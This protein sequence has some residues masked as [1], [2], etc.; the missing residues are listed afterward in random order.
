MRFISGI[1]KTR[2]RAEL[3]KAAQ[4]SGQVI[5][6]TQDGTVSLSPIDDPMLSGINMHR[7]P[8][9]RVME[10]AERQAE[11]SRRH[12]RGSEEDVPERTLV[13]VR[14]PSLERGM[15][16]LFVAGCGGGSRV[17]EYGREERGE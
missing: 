3:E 13:A 15:E 5:V 9:D 11:K 1:T 8:T 14:S 7:T 4:A 10:K 12:M 16:G 6:D 2:E 17:G